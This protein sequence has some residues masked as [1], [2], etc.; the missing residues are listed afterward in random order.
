MAIFI[1]LIFQVLFVFFAMI[2]NIGLTV[3]DK[4]NLQNSVDLAAYYAA[5]KQAEILNLLAHI[6]YQIRLDYKLLAY[7]QRVIG[8]FGNLQHPAYSGSVGPFSDTQ[9]TG[10]NGLLAEQPAI[11]I[12]HRQWKDFQAGGDENLCRETLNRVAELPQTPVIAAFN[13]INAVLSSLV[14]SLRQGIGE[15]CDNGAGANWYYAALANYAFKVDVARRKKAFLSVAKTLSDNQNDFVDL[16]GSLVS[17]GTEK[18][19]EKNLTIANKN[20]IVAMGGAG[21]SKKILLFNSLGTGGAADAAPK[22]LAEIPIEPILLYVFHQGSAG[23]CD[24]YIRA[25]TNPNRPPTANTADP[26]GALQAYIGEPAV[27]NLFHSS[28]GY[29]KN[30][31]YMAYVATYA[32]TNPRKPFAPFGGAIKLKA[33]AFAKPFGG[34]IGPWEMN[35]WS[36][37]ASQSDSGSPVDPLAVP[38]ADRLKV[39]GNIAADQIFVPNYSRYPGDKLGLKSTLAAAYGRGFLNPVNPAGKAATA[40]Y[41]GITAINQPNGDPLA[42]DPNFPS[43]ALYNAEVAALAPD[44]FD[45]TYYSIQPEFNKTY[46]SRKL[47][48]SLKIPFD[49]GSKQNLPNSVMASYLA[50]T[51]ARQAMPEANFFYLL[52]RIDHTLTDWTQSSEA[53][54]NFP[55]DKF[56]T[57]TA[58]PSPADPPV[59]GDCIIGGRTGY[60]VKLISREYLIS[61]EHS[62]G[63]AT[64][65]KGAIRNQPPAVFLGN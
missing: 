57:C 37:A 12:T 54:Y 14:D 17:Q 39:S 7:R 19:L 30:P 46:L 34:R 62:L 41:A 44:L 43:N 65:G 47:P 28:R 56:G 48:Q 23:R 33:V 21:G 45:T 15:S 64:S 26:Q 63:G 9:M 5:S 16:D 20:G 4:I 27:T 18:T 31:W 40:N 50:S 36:A 38:R 35:S 2:I 6:N 3:H 49:I 51:S 58:R 8:G 53:D 55:V 29:E 13:P 25:L 61:S 11:C 42:F 22:W 1:A 60:S 32:E 52:N 24:N 10:D 59:D